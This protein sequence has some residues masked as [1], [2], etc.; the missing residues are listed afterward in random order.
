MKRLSILLIP[1]VASCS[2]LGLSTS[3]ADKNQNS[4]I[5]VKYSNNVLGATI[6]I[7]PHP[8]VIAIN[9]DPTLVT[10]SNLIPGKN[11]STEILWIRKIPDPRLYSG[12]DTIGWVTS[13]WNPY[14]S[15]TVIEVSDTAFNIIPD[16][17]ITIE[18]GKWVKF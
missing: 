10:E 12:I 9:Y 8:T 1:L 4:A 3:Q 17:S 18:R 14:F 13:K 7:T 16:S 15:Y 2:Y 6:K 5:I 11:F